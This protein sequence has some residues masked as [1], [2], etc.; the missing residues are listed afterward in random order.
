[1][2]FLQLNTLA[3]DLRELETVQG[4]R[5]LI[6]DLKRAVAYLPAAH[7]IHVA[8]PFSRAGNSVQRFFVSRNDSVPDF[9]VVIS[10]IRVAIEAKQLT[11]SEPARRF[12]ATASVLKK[13]LSAEIFREGQSYP[14]IQIIVGDALNI[15]D[16]DE[17]VAGIKCALGQYRDGVSVTV[18]SDNV[19]IKLIPTSIAGSM[20]N[21]RAMQVV[22]PRDDSEDTRIERLLNK[23]NK[24]LKNVTGGT[25]PGLL[26]LAIGEHQDPHA[27]VEIIT[28]KFGG[29]QFRSISGV[30]VHRYARHIGPGRIATAD[31]LIF[32]GHPIGHSQVPVF[33]LRGTG[34]TGDL[35]EHS[36]KD[37]TVS[38]YAVAS[39]EARVTDAS[40]GFNMG[41]NPVQRIEISALPKRA[42][43]S[44]PIT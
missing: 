34:V 42:R 26:C 19:V 25:A 22:A 24:Q 40:T 35:L 3:E 8:A 9:E 32:V 10:G 36:A 13:Q 30:I 44:L 31:M 43:V 41:I 38:C 27:V 1:M 4:L 5:T 12:S 20:D 18:R 14:E 29:S 21:H 16:A 15:P 6:D 2:A 28:R 39:V 7:T 17:I 11:T 23:A 37:Q 33:Q